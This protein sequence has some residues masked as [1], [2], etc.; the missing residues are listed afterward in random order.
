MLELQSRKPGRKKRRPSNWE[1]ALALLAIGPHS[2][3]GG[4]G[5]LEDSGSWDGGVQLVRLEPWIYIHT[6]AQISYYMCI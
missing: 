3:S 5:G 2:K 1:K 4:E 6:Y